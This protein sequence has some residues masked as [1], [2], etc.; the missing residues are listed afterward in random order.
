MDCEKAKKLIVDFFYDELDSDEVSGLDDHLAKCDDCSEYRQEIEL[1]IKCLDKQEEVA[2]SVN[3][4]ALH[5]AIEQKRSWN[6]FKYRIPV[7]ATAL[8]II[9]A[10][11]IS[12]FA[13]SKAE[14]QYGNNTLT[15]SF[16]QPIK[17]QPKEQTVSID[18]DKIYAEI[19]KVAQKTAYTLEQY[20]KEQVSFQDKLSK[21]LSDYRTET[22]SLIGEYDQQNNQR[23]AQLIQQLQAQ[24]YQSLVA[25][26]DEFEFLASRTQNE[27]ERS[28]M[29]MAAMAEVLS[30]NGGQ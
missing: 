22:A 13:L 6:P 3:L 5:E 15:I 9:F 29:T 20:K 11:A 27:F 28:Y 14:I 2:S 30:Y 17:E 23:T 18:Y 8:F 25:I 21:E 10:V 4:S 19:D 12:A 7:W 26:K 16:G 24:H 1:S